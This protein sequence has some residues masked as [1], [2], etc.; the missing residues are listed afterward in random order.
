MNYATQSQASCSILKDYRSIS[1]P[2][3][4]YTSESRG[5]KKEYTL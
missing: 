5:A 4:D 3:K 2:P 1:K